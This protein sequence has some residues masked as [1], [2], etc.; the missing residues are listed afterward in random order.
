MKKILLT[1]ALL[2][3]LLISC[4]SEAVTE[5]PREPDLTHLNPIPAN[6]VNPYDM[7]GKAHIDIFNEYLT[8]NTVNDTT[9]TKIRQRIKDLALAN[10]DLMYVN[11]GYPLTDVSVEEIE[12]I[13][14]KPDV[15]L[16]AIITASALT[17]A[18][19]TQ[20]INFMDT[21]QSLESE[22]YD[23]LYK[24][25]V[26]YEFSIVEN[27]HLNDFDKRVLLLT[28]AVLRHWSYSMRKREDKDWSKSTGNHVGVVKGAILS[29]YTAVTTS[30]TSTIAQNKN[31][32]SR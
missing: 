28:S 30:L 7:A 26:S 29:P 31:V 3:S 8:I 10:S 32:I 5:V 24:Y 23:V 9:I 12:Q 17:P 14:I 25:I 18:A 20:L 11:V 15:E 6:P 4:H 1:F 21:V 19:K 22:Q 2:S 27:A 16:N 13:L